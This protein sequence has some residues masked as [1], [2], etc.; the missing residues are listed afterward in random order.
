MI[1]SARHNPLLIEELEMLTRTGIEQGSGAS[2]YAQRSP[3]ESKHGSSAAIA[4]ENGYLDR[5]DGND[6]CGQDNLYQ[7][8]HRFGHEDRTWLAIM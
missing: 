8:D 7:T 3:L 4:Q 5:G 2:E 1:R 6:W